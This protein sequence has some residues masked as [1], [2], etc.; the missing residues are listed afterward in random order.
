MTQDAE[1]VERHPKAYNEGYQWCKNNKGDLIFCMNPYTLGDER[2]TA[3]A[4]GW[5]TRRDEITNE[6]NS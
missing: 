2:H 3:W 6:T 5:R 4:I 1:L